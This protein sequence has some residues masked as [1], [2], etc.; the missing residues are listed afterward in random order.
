[1]PHLLYNYTHAIIFTLNEDDVEIF[2]FTNIENKYWQK[3]LY[4]YKHV[5]Y[6]ATNADMLLHVKMLKVHLS[7]YPCQC[8]RKHDQSNT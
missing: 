3:F 1:M 8:Q 2:Y 5:W 7:S 6:T 4:E